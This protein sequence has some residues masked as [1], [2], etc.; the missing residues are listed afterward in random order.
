LFSKRGS[1]IRTNPTTVVVNQVTQFAVN[2]RITSNKKHK[3]AS[4]Y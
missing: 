1:W 3:I 2:Q 4:V